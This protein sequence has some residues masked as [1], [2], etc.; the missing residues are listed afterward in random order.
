[1]FIGCTEIKEEDNNKDGIED[2]AIDTG[3]E[4]EEET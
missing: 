4:E 2:S 3:E 1:M